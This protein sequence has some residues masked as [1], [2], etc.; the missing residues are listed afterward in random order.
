MA[1][2]AK[3]WY[4]VS[5]KSFTLKFIFNT[6][7][8]VILGDFNIDINRENNSKYL[9]T[10]RE[11]MNMTPVFN[12]CLTFKDMSQLDWCLKMIDLYFA[13]YM[14]QTDGLTDGHDSIDFFLDID[15]SAKN[16]GNPNPN[17]KN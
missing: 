3:F 16:L 7:S 8:L 6:D 15:K 17:K 4:R 11:N 12:K 14:P 9:E 2:E 5:V 13:R 10:F 1:F